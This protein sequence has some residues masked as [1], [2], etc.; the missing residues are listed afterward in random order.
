MVYL[1]RVPPFA[2]VSQPFRQLSSLFLR[3]HFTIGKPWHE[4]Y[5][6]CITGE[7][8]ERLLIP[9]TLICV[10]D[11]GNKSQEEHSPRCRGNDARSSREEIKF[12]PLSCSRPR[13]TDSEFR[14]KGKHRSIDPIFRPR[15]STEETVFSSRNNFRDYRS[16]R[17]DQF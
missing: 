1:I 7:I 9:P 3:V 11:R 17:F 4:K 14:F 8:T 2:N 13:T 6:C 15:F 5:L 10:V 12:P 16:N